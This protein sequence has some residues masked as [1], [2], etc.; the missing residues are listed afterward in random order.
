MKAMR[1]RALSKNWCMGGYKS[2]LHLGAPRLLAA[3]ALMIE[4]YKKTALI[5]H[6]VNEFGVLF[7]N[8][9]EI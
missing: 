7:I 6:V 3:H 9:S 4:K 1:L 2:V 8:S 5:R